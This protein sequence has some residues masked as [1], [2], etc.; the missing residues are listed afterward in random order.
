[1]RI[2][3][4]TRSDEI[5]Y[6]QYSSFICIAKTAEDAALMHPDN[7]G[8]HRWNGRNWQYKIAEE[9]RDK[10]FGNTWADP[11]TLIV[12]MF[13]KTPKSITKPHIVLAS[14]HAG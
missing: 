12:E 5:D 9:W 14:F 7:Y 3:K 8:E 11:N 4:V 2:F 10:S 13:G 1:M 6:D